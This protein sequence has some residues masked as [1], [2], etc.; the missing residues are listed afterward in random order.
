[1]HRSSNANFRI[2]KVPS[3]EVTAVG[4]VSAAIYPTWAPE[5]MFSPNR[6]TGAEEWD[7]HKEKP[8]REGGASGGSD[9]H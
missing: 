7:T 3:L 1:M 4:D 9:V 2:L 8:R 5:W 6:D